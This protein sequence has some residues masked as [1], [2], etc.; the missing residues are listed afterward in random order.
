MAN[1]KET[2]KE[3]QKQEFDRN[4]IDPSLESKVDAMM[5]SDLPEPP[6]PEKPALTPSRKDAVSVGAPLLPTEK[7][8]KIKIFQ[9]EPAKKDIPAAASENPKGETLVKADET[10]APDTEPADELE[11]D[12]PATGKIV[13]AIVAE[14]ADELLAAE[15][16]RAGKD[17]Q[18]PKLLAAQSRPKSK[19]KVFFKAWFGNKLYRR[20]TILA[21]VVALATAA[22]VPTSRYFLLN[23]AGVR[24]SSSMVVLDQA[25]KQ[26]LKNVEVSLGGQTAKT[27]K[28]GKVQLDRIKL[29]SQQLSIKKVAYG[30]L[31]KDLN[32]GWGSNPLGEMS[33][34]PIGSRYTFSLSDFLA[35]NPIAKAEAASG[36]AS[37]VT[38]AKGEA[39]LSIPHTDDPEIEITITAENYRTEV[40]KIPNTT[41]ASQQI[42][43]VPARKMVF[44]SKRSGIYDVYKIDVDGKNEQ[45]ILPGTGSEQP[46]NM[47][48]VSHPTKELVAFVSSRGNVRNKDGFLLSTLNIINLSDDS[49]TKIRQSERI[50]IIDWIGDRL[51]YVAVAEGVSAASPQRHRLLTYDLKEEQGRE[52]ASTN[53]FNDVMV[54]RGAI[55]YSPAI[56]KINGAVGLFRIN[57]DGSGKKTISDKE[58]WNLFRTSFDRISVSVGQDWYDY[59]IPDGKYSKAAGAPPALISRLYI[60]SPDDSRS[61]W[62]EDR[63]GKGTLLIYDHKSKEDKVIHAQSG[64]KNPVRWLDNDHL[65]YRVTGGEETA[66]YVLSLKGGSPQKIIDVTNTAGTDRWYYY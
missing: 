43:L 10:E 52:L 25:T 62:V 63:D 57:A 46:D 66:D 35:G 17:P 32:I 60:D 7:L 53:Y 26:P 30:E 34:T 20:L 27:D 59:N 39:V 65:V 44:V 23:T 1:K 38:N 29:G 37:A 16:E 6:I 50:Q 9:E 45:K 61:A 49:T 56:Y 8:R 21:V 22:T 15:D 14:E 40:F 31:N 55:Y 19:L 41:K 5:N 24:A 11:L 47:T 13:D 12:D 4:N 48:I 28:E 51:V 58:A 18:A 33:L 54:A 64:L 2:S 3:D 36:E 42:K